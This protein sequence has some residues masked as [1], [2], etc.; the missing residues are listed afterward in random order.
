[1]KTKIG[2]LLLSCLMVLALVLASCR[3]APAEE[4]EVVTG[5]VVEKEAVEKEEAPPAK[6]GPKYGGIIQAVSSYEPSSLDPHKGVS[7][8]DA[9]YWRQTHDVLMGANVKFEPDPSLGLAESWEMPNNTTMIFH[10]RKGI[11]FHDGTDFNA[12]AVK[13]NI[14][15]C[16]NP[17]VA[18]TPKASFDVIDSVEVLDDY[19]IKFNLKQPWGGV[20]DALG[21]R[22][23]A[24]NSPAAVQK[25]GK[26]YGFNPV[27]TGPFKLEEYVSGSYCK[28]VRNDDYWMKDADG[29]SL[30]Y[31]DGVKIVLIKD[32]TVISAALETG[33]LDMAWIPP[34][35][36]EK[37]EKNPDFYI[38]KF[39]GSGVGPLWHFN[40]TIP[41]ADN[42]YF[43]KAICYGVNPEAVNQAVYFGRMTVADSGMWT[44]SSWAYDPDVER[45]Y[46]DPEKAREF[47]KKSGYPEGI[48]VDV[49]TWNLPTLMQTA[50][51]YQAQLAEIGIDIELHVFDVGTAS[52]KMWSTREFPVFL[53]SWSHYPEPD[54][55]CR[56]NYSKDGYYNSGHV[57]FPEIEELIKAG[58]SIYDIDKRKAIYKRINQH[59][60]EQCIYVPTLYSNGYMGIHKYIKG[61]TFETLFSGTAK[62][63]YYRL[64][65]EK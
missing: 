63:L 21:D 25:Y 62:A 41:P 23:G 35:D 53:T 6:E 17:E 56:L 7:G 38:I 4:E 3:P 9:E 59:I 47:L 54:H 43:R 19:T 55:I 20:V 13:W 5:K 49:D 26:D 57:E 64:W 12:E 30:P 8:A 61:A 22:G 34:K 1:M 2:W 44:P 18:A 40:L 31:V 51:M 27:G 45:P 60:L 36:I 24:M 65:I 37:F 50:E 52:Q 48:K 29:N 15:R 28:L 33:E 42:L 14:E 16:M 32:P 11:Q 39:P 10:L 46:Y 58:A